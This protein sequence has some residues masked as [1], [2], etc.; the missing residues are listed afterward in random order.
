MNTATVLPHVTAGLNAVTALFLVAG[1]AFIRRR[2][3]AAH[4]AA[5]LGA[6]GASA[7]FLVAYLTYHF[8]A[9][10]FVFQGQ[11]AVRPVYYALLVSHVLFAAVATPMVLLTLARGLLGRFEVHR[12]LARWTLPVWLYSSVS[13]LAVYVMLYQMTWA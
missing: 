13:G 1:F 12:G 10:I 2:D 5:M 11:G 3:R 8:T 6:V 4:R 9:P 7:L